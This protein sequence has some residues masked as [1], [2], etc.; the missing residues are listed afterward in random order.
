MI[1]F[2]NLTHVYAFDTI[3]LCVKSEYLWFWGD[4]KNY[5]LCL[6]YFVLKI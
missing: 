6:K 3:L 5:S 2:T 4:F 1:F